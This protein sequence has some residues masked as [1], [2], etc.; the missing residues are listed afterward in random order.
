[1]GGAHG[2]RG[3][4]WL[5]PDLRRRAGQGFAVTR[6]VTASPAGLQVADPAERPLDSTRLS[7]SAKPEQAPERVLETRTPDPDVPLLLT[8]HTELKGEGQP[9]E[10]RALGLCLA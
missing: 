1:M 3:E 10:G 5:P 6:T 9:R 7:L 2:F 8:L 4:V